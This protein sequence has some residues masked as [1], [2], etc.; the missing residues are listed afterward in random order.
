MPD[1]VSTVLALR[2]FIAAKTISFY[3]LDAYG[4][5]WSEEEWGVHPRLAFVT[6]HRPATTNPTHRRPPSRI[7]TCWAAGLLLDPK[8]PMHPCAGCGVVT[9]RPAATWGSTT[10]V[11]RVRGPPPRFGGGIQLPPP[12]CLS[13][14]YPG[15]APGR[16]LA[17]CAAAREVVEAGMTVTLIRSHPTKIPSSPLSAGKLLDGTVM[18]P[19]YVQHPRLHVLRCLR[20]DPVAGAAVTGVRRFHLRRLTDK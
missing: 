15:R 6:S 1:P 5:S 14:P 16:A 10:P 20:A 4:A 3:F 8:P 18:P 13:D 7:E 11:K 19:A 17:A 9:K 2:P 12:L